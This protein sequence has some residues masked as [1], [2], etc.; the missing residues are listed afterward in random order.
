MQ[1]KK[2]FYVEYVSINHST[3]NSSFE[4]FGCDKIPSEEHIRKIM[5]KNP[6]YDHAQVYKRT[7]DGVELITQYNRGN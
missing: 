7:P 6:H 5:K 3:G 2:Q 4:K 1:A